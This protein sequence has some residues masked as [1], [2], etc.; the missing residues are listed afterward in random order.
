MVGFVTMMD[1]DRLLESGTLAAY[2]VVLLWIGIR[3]SRKV[4]TSLD[5]TLA[6]RGVP[7]AIVMATAAA[8][9]IGG[10]ASVG[11]VSRVYEVGIAAAFITCA[12]HLQ[13]IFTGW[14][15]APKLRG[16]NLITVGDYFHVKLGP[17][18]RELAV[19]NCV[20]FLV[21][22]LAAQMAAI[23]TVANN[24]LGVRYEVALLIGAAVTVFYSTVGGMRA[25]ITTDVLQFVI[26]V[27]GI[28][29][30]A[31]TLVVQQGGF[32]EMLQQTDPEHFHLTGNWS[33]IEVISLFFAFLLGETF[34]PPY[35]VRCFVAQDAAQARAG[36]AG[37][38]IFLLFFL[39]VATFAL[40]TSARIQPEVR[41]AIQQETDRNLDEAA[42]LGRQMS[43][44]EA[45]GKARQIA[46]PAL[47]RATLP[48]IF[49]GIVV[50]AII[51]AVMSSADSCL[52]CL[53][54]V[55]MEDYYRRHI[56]PQASDRGL[57][58]IAQ[59]T[60]LIAGSGAAVWALFQSNVA[61][62]LVFIYDFWAPTMVLPFLV[63]L[64]W[65]R[66]ARI[67]SVVLS[68]IAGT[69]A[70]VTWRFGLDSP[71]DI[72]PALFGFAVAVVTFFVSL[73]LSGLWPTGP[74]LQPGVETE[75]E[76]TP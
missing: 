13:L 10:G 36:V 69:I 60:T 46:F 62:L 64:F 35:A 22:A 3:S 41:Q 34:V 57:L 59:G 20:I 29:A 74:L 51:A 28:G 23:G 18:A 38:G 2:L 25:V 49:A 6:G 66:P 19:V 27:V 32:T 52:S 26:L 33:G 44:E 48:P 12:W 56:N 58:R 9:M 5:F 47:V 70:T 55:V 72:G 53:A 50:A 7:W 15:V 31:A 61:E 11:M 43:E 8:T 21:G 67:P 14:F 1:T 37:A 73:P 40:G 71:W 45:A 24:V 68:M 16:M 76:K 54:T 30:A 63:A 4:K 65:Y 75:P 17:I 39:P 42:R